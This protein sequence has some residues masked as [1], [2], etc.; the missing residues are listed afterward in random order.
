[1]DSRTKNREMI[2]ATKKGDI[3]RVIAIADADSQFLTMMTPFGTWLHVAASAG[4]LEIVKYH[5]ARG[6]NPNERGGTFWGGALNLA[7]AAGHVEVADYILSCGAEIDVSEPERNP[8]FAAIYGGHK[9]IVQLLLQKGVDVHIRYSGE[10][11]H[12][13]DAMAFARARGQSAIAEILASAV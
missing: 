5:I 11:M 1:V 3:Q 7:A 2:E 4:Q 9:E 12:D 10:N 6:L 13:M 8:L